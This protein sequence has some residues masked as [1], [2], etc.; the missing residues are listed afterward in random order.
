MMHKSYVNLSLIHL[1]TNTLVIK[2]IQ[3]IKKIKINQ[4]L[5]KN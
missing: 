3:K 4:L 5:K 1:L 2:Y